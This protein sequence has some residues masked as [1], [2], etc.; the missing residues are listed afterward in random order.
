METVTLLKKFGLNEKEIKVY[1]VLLEYGSLSV[2]KLSSLSGVNRGTTYDILK[3][4]KSQGLVSYYHK[5]TKQLFVAEDPEK[6]IQA[7]KEKEQSLID[8]TKDI[9]TILP[10]LRSLYNKSGGKP[11]VKFYEGQKAMKTILQDVLDTTAASKEK[12]YYIFSSSTIRPYLHKSWATFTEE[13]VKRGIY[14]HAIALGHI[15]SKAPLSI[16][17]CLTPKEGSPTYVLIYN[18][19]VAM[20]S[21]N[22]NKE[23]MGLIVEDE[24]LFKT[25]LQIFKFIWQTL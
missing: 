4:L 16:R 9:E 8:V 25:Q 20:I 7:L 6:L 12:T 13:R 23:L 1:L 2:R 21:V 22:D 19:K 15:G 18:G 24:A 3:S 5:D 11:I 17:K 10:S 14:T